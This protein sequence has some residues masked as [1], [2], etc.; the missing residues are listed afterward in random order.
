M[1][2]I[3]RKR[4]KLQPILRNAFYA[5]QTRKEKPRNLAL[6]RSR[7][8]ILWRE[9]RMGIHMLP[10]FCQRC[11]WESYSASDYLQINCF[12]H[13]SC[14]SDYGNVTRRNRAKEKY[15]I[16]LKRGNTSHIRRQSGRPTKMD[17]TKVSSGEKLTR[18]MTS[19]HNKSLCVICQQPEKVNWSMTSPHNKSLCVICQQPEKVTRSMTSPHNKSLC[20]ICQQPEK[21]TRSMT[22]PHNKSL[23]VICQQPEKV[24]RSMTSPQNKSV[25][26]I[27]QQP[28]GILHKWS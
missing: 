23:C 9:I 6:R 13:I 22:S 8:I 3:P 19:P 20:V 1:Y 14:Y 21:V 11:K 12:Y 27:C 15:E 4:A 10:M 7:Q 17:G 5:K 16:M 24:T 25:C 26:V 18:S 2:Y 28:E